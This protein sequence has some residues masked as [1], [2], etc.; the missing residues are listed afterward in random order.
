[1]RVKSFSHFLFLVFWF[2]FLGSLLRLLVYIEFS[3]LLYEPLV[4]NVNVIGL[5]Q[6]ISCFL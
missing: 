1:M 3:I 5:C 2:P 6:Y 4:Y